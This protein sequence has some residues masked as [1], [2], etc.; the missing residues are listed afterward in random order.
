MKRAKKTGGRIIMTWDEFCTKAKR[1]VGKT[2]EKINRT[3][4]IAALQIKLSSLENK[5]ADAYERLGKVAYAH[6]SNENAD[7]TEKLAQRMAEVEE[8]LQNV[9]QMKE[10]IEQLKKQDQETKAE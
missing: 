7:L 4:D 5:A 10:K 8:A 3:A 9:A 1:T 6:L 2:A